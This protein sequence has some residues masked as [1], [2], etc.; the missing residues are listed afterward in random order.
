MYNIYIQ[1]YKYL[2]LHIYSITHGFSACI[3]IYKHLME[4][5][6]KMGELLMTKLHKIS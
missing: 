1:T 6:N 2:K 4:F 5:G 3:H